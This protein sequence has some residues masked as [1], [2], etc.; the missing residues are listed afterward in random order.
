MKQQADYR[1][2]AMST[3]HFMLDDF[4]NISRHYSTQDLTSNTRWLWHRPIVIAAKDH[5]DYVLANV[6]HV[7]FHR[8]Y[9]QRSNVR[10]IL[11]T[12]QSPLATN[13]CCRNRRLL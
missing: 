7:S 6:M 10:T 13:T 11:S 3:C 2:K 12:K 9:H 5:S 1:Y 8:R 4:G